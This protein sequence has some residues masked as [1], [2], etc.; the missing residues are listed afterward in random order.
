MKELDGLSVDSPPAIESQNGDPANIHNPNNDKGLLVEWS[1]DADD[2]DGVI[3]ETREVL[4][5]TAPEPEE[6]DEVI[7]EEDLPVQVSSL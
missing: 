2:R 1:V 5:Q 3:K 7:T 4:L 6:G